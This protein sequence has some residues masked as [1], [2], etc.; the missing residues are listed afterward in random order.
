MGLKVNDKET[1]T[2]VF[3]FRK[4]LLSAFHSWQL[5]SQGKSSLPG[6]VCSDQSSA[7]HAHGDTLANVYPENE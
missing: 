2:E 7:E 3:F 6:G 1:S 5:Q 4:H